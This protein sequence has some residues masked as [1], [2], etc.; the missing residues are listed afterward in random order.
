MNR[1]L[2]LLNHQ[3]QLQEA[4]M[5]TG[6]MMLYKKWYHLVITYDDMPAK[7]EVFVNS[8]MKYSSDMSGLSDAVMENFVYFGSAFLAEDMK[9]TGTLACVIMY[10]KVL[11]MEEIR[12]VSGMCDSLIL[13][14]NC[15]ILQQVFLQFM[16][17]S[18]CTLN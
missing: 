5:P 17:G 4:V 6:V 11:E 9:M 12:N 13:G 14:K 18:L 3:K 15:T 8:A 16:R 10:N 2:Y 7:T 1:E